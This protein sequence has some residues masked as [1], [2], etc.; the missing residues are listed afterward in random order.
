MSHLIRQRYLHFKIREQGGAYGSGAL[1][2]SDWQSFA[3]FSARDPNILA[4]KEIFSKA[5]ID[6][7]E[8]ACSSDELGE[9]KRLAIQQQDTPMQ[10]G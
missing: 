2:R 7:G 5:L 4:T 3:L 10:P 8:I 9:A 6:S 1:C